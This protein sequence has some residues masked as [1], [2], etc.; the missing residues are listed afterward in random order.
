[1]RILTYVCSSWV[2]RE[3]VDPVA[4]NIPTY[5]DIIPKR[6]ARDLRTIRHKLDTDQYD[7]VEAFEADIAL[8]VRNAITFNGPE[9]EIAVVARLLK[10]KVKDML[11]GIKPQAPAERE[12]EMKLSS[13]DKKAL[14]S[15]LQK[16]VAEDV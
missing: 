15:V 4:L 6:D 8:M 1:M 7:S 16:L 10:H 5:F 11:S 2:F 3:P 9:S 12:K 13:S 14:Q